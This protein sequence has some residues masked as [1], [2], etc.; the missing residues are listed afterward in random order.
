MLNRKP[1]G[2]LTVTMV[3]CALSLFLASCSDTGDESFRRVENDR[4]NAY[5]VTVIAIEMEDKDSGQPIDVGGEVI[6]GSVII[7]PAR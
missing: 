6:T 3:A 1:L 5:T 2:R 7:R 4:P